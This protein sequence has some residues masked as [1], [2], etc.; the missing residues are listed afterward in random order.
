M[1]STAIDFSE[2]TLFFNVLGRNT[3]SQKEQQQLSL[4]ASRSE[5]FP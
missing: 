3:E 2:V 1:C 5:T 4:A